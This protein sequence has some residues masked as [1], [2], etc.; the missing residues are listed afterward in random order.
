MKDTA[1]AQ[2]SGT[3]I[4]PS[5]IVC[6]AIDRLALSDHR[7]E[8]NLVFINPGARQLTLILSL[9]SSADKTFVRPMRADLLTE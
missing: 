3:P 1:P 7:A 8:L 4:L 2:S 6:S 5:G 9:A